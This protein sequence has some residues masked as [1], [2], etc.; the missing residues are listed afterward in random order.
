MGVIAGLK[1]IRV[2]IVGA[3][4]TTAKHYLPRWQK[5]D[6]VEVVAVANRSKDSARRVAGRFDIAQV[7]DHWPSLVA[8]DEVD[9]VYVGTWPYLHRDV[10]IA[11][12]NNG[13]HVLTQA[14]MAMSSAE[15]RDMLASARLHPNLVAQVVPTR[16]ISHVLRVLPELL[17]SGYTGDVLSV[18]IIGSGNANSTSS[19]R[20][21]QDLSGFNMMSVGQMA[22]AITWLLGPFSSVSAIT[23]LYNPR[24]R[25]AE[26]CTYVADIPD[27]VEV[28]A[29]LSCGTIVHLRDSSVTHLGQER[30]RIF[31]THG[32]LELNSR[33]GLLGARRGDPELLP[34]PIP[35][36]DRHEINDDLEFFDSIRLGT[37]VEHTSFEDGVRYM[38][39]TEAVVRSSQIRESVSLPL[40][41]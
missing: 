4:S 23:R 17:G 28:I 38:E 35:Q 15:A 25:D 14:R 37:P 40:V 3:G 1:T 22:E 34:L 24:R 2:G 9:A 36:E 20:N 8:S 11:A 39:F 16:H 41:P 32:T 31:G 27:L 7:H 18:D 5:M 6:G 21:K 30:L 29:E 33:Q 10:S 19:W 12:L 26:D 13:K